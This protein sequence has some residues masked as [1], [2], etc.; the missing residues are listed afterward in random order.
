MSRRADED[1]TL[2]R[3]AQLAAEPLRR[4][5]GSLSQHAWR[6]A[7]ISEVPAEFRGMLVEFDDKSFMKFRVCPKENGSMF[8]SYESLLAWFGG[9]FVRSFH[10]LERASG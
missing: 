7:D 5:D 1:S 10:Q 4:A 9:P 3:A 2:C 8:D 6:E